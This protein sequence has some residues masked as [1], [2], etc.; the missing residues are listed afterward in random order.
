MNRRPWGT[1]RT[2]RGVLS[3]FN[4]P[5][6]SCIQDASVLTGQP[7]KRITATK[8]RPQADRRHVRLHRGMSAVLGFVR[9][10][11]A[12]TGMFPCSSPAAIGCVLWVWV[13]SARGILLLRESDRGRV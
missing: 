4:G 7:M 8:G 12:A 1:L 5:F 3:L 13:G 6:F 2:A 10:G 9:T 11:F